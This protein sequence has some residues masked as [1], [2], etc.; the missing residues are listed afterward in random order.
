M[1]LQGSPGSDQPGD[2]PANVQGDLGGGVVEHALTRAGVA[3]AERT[4]AGTEAAE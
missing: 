2:L 1:S 4:L 3:L